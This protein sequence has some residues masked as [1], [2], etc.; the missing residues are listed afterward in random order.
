MVLD[1]PHGI[2]SLDDF[3][4]SPQTTMDELLTS[5][6]PVRASSCDYFCATSPVSVDGTD[7]LPEFSFLAGHLLRLILRPCIEY[8]AS[9]AD[10]CERQQFRFVV[11]ARWL[12]VRL[13]RPTEQPKGENRYI[14][15]WGH[16][17]AVADISPRSEHNA[18]YIVLNRKPVLCIP[19]QVPISSALPGSWAIMFLYCFIIFHRHFLNWCKIRCKLTYPDLPLKINKAGHFSFLRSFIVN[20]HC[21]RDI[22]MPHD[23]LN[24]LEIFLVLAKTSAKC[25]P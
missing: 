22:R 12:F 7:F 14:F 8:P 15:P 13:G 5:G 11:C 19:P 18:G 3:P 4:F 20:I 6:L 17:S 1:L 9:M 16:I 24:N 2:L 23:F 25:M 10:Q 21:C